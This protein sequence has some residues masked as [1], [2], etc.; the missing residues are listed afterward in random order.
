VVQLVNS[1]DGCWEST[2]RPGS[3]T[4]NTAVLYEAGS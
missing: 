3:V 4:S 1:I 2:F